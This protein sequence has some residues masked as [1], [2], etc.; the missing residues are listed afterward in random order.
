MAGAV[1][2]RSRPKGGFL[3]LVGVWWV[4]WDF[5]FVVVF[6]G[7]WL[8]CVVCSPVSS[9]LPCRDRSRS[10]SALVVPCPCLTTTPTI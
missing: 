7:C 6:V 8:L 1:V 4:F 5:L 3:F 2:D 9:S 10:A